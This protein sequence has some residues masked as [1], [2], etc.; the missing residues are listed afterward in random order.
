MN[1]I[2]KPCLGIISYDDDQRF[3]APAGDDGILTEDAW[4]ANK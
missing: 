2:G 4:I 3:D 1:G